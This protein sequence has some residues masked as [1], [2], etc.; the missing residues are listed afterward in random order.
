[1]SET[2]DDYR[3]LR[4]AEQRKRQEQIDSNVE[5]LNSSQVDYRWVEQSATCIIRRGLRRVDFYASKNRWRDI[6][7]QT[8]HDGDAGDLIRWMRAPQDGGAA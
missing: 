5:I 1:M 4:L 2:S 8:M 3:A 6:D 7:T